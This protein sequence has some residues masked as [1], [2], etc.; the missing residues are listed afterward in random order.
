MSRPMPSSDLNVDSNESGPTKKEDAYTRHPQ[1]LPLHLDAGSGFH[2]FRESC[3][4][5]LHRCYRRILSFNPR[6]ISGYVP[7][8]Y[9]V[10]VEIWEPILLGAITSPLLPF[11]T[12]G[13]I[14]DSFMMSYSL[15]TPECSMFR[16]YRNTTQDTIIRLSLVC[17]LWAR[18]L[19]PYTQLCAL[20][21]LKSVQFPSSIAMKEAKRIF[22]TE[23][24]TCRCWEAEMETCPLRA[25]E[26]IDL[27]RVYSRQTTSSLPMDLQ[28]A[29]ILTVGNLVSTH[30]DFIPTLPRLRALS[31]ASPKLVNRWDV[32]KALAAL[33][34]LTHFHVARVGADSFRVRG[35]TFPHLR[36]LTLEF[37]VDIPYSRNDTS[38]KTWKA[39]KLRTLHARGIWTSDTRQAFYELASQHGETLTELIDTTRIERNQTLPSASFWMSCLSLEV[40]GINLEIVFDNRLGRYIY[41]ID[42][43]NSILAPLTLIVYD[44]TVQWEYGLSVD[45]S[46][47]FGRLEEVVRKLNVE[48]IVSVYSWEDMERNRKGIAK[49]I[50]GRFTKERR[51][52]DRIRKG[53]SNLLEGLSVPIYDRLG[54]SF[55]DAVQTRYL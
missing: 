9:R 26:K 44:I 50:N 37:A 32:D 15:F 41:N 40:Y 33:P 7:A 38:F 46:F 25:L 11:G 49:C 21:D 42:Q 14:P 29:Q 23:F 1:R 28:S 18:I 22:I 51:K 10:P 54:I 34:Q 8:A 53:F 4:D 55:S 16:T 47:A 27:E 36:S 13:E 6:L 20:T 35:L 39:P 3:N 17:R 43:R 5:V 19:E 2:S 52:F 48:K 31:L 12:N 24:D 45:P 30:L